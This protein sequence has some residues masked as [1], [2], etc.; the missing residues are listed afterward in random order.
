MTTHK[1]DH[2][3]VFALARKHLP[4]DKTANARSCMADAMR[5]SSW[6]DADKQ[7]RAILCALRSL[8]YS[9]GILHADY[10][11][12]FNAAGITGPVRLMS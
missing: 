6:A 10:A 5:L 4:S 7:D 8:A 9:I 12:A 2:A 1:T 11:R 3:K